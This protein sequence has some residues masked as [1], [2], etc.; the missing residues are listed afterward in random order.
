[1]LDSIIPA[2]Q[3]FQILGNTDDFEKWLIKNHSGKNKEQFFIG[4]KFALNC[5][6]NQFVSSI[7]TN[8]SLGLEHDFLF[9]RAGYEIEPIDKLENTCEKIVFL[10]NI[11]PYV[12]KV[13]KSKT[14]DELKINVAN[15]QEVISSKFEIIYN[16]YVFVKAGTRLGKSRIKELSLLNFAHTF[17]NQI[18]ADGPIANFRNMLSVNWSGEKY[19]SRSFEGFKYTLQFLWNRVLGD[20]VYNKSSLVNLH[21]AETW[22][23]YTYIKSEEKGIFAIMDR[24]FNLDEQTSLDSYFVRVQKEITEPLG[25]RIKAMPYAI[26]SRLEFKPFGYNK[27]KLFG[28]LLKADHLINP[29]NSL[30]T[31]DKI[32]NRLYWFS[33]E[34]IDSH[35][36]SLHVG[37]ASFNTMLA[38]TVALHNPSESEFKKTVVAKFTHPHNK[39]RNENDYSYGIL[40]DT[41]SAAGH[42]SSGWVIYLNA[43]G[44]Y[45]GFSGSEHEAAEKLIQQYKEQDKI[46]LRE[47]TVSLKEFTNFTDTYSKSSEEQ[48]IT[49]QNKLI[50]QIIQQAKGYAFELFVFYINS[51]FFG[52]HFKVSFN[53]DQNNI[54]GEKDIVLS[55]E[56]EVIIIE[57]KLNLKNQ[58]V[59]ELIGKL[60]KKLEQYPQKTKSGELWFWENTSAI[61]TERITERK[62]KTV[63]V[64]ERTEPNLKTVDLSRLEFIMQD[65]SNSYSEEF[66]E[67]FKDINIIEEV[68]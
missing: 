1:M 57:C 4:Y 28:D 65:Y 31:E 30:S 38:G 26:D 8:T 36:S 64:K 35:N 60:E 39:E 11:K 24:R 9:G 22:E 32:K 56:N 34:I 46:E 23:K 67:L 7:E 25:K 43:C 50:P 62:I 42:Y 10:K 58:N 45:S 14:Y 37:I 40:V 27:T 19:L 66:K 5:C 54:L 15:F 47:L 29:F 6:L 41:K 55:N 61:S 44:D 59:H 51:D 17:L 2:L 16:K 33:C 20:E 13:T 12:K 53:V 63:F 21:T 49:D 3:T 48:R 18:G 52:E 68:G